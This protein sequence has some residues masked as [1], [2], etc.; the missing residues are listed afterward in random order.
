[1][2]HC[3]MQTYRFVSKIVLCS[4]GYGQ[5]SRCDIIFNFYKNL[6]KEI[7]FILTDIT[8]VIALVWELTAKDDRGTFKDNRNDFNAGYMGICISQNSSSSCI[9]FQ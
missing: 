9:Q 6:K 3:Y 4:K 7:Q 2:I 1:M 5:T 8:S